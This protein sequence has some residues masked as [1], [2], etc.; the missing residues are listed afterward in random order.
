MIK[1]LIMGLSGAGKTTLA[2]ALRNLIQDNNKTVD[3]FNADLIRQAYDDWDFSVEGRIRQSIRMRDLAD[4]MTSDYVI[5]DFVCPLPVM[6]ENFAAD[7]VVWVDTLTE[8]RYA[9]TNQMFVAPEKYNI[10]VIEQHA[11]KWAKIIY[12]R[13]SHK[14]VE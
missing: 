5:C 2:E 6:R 3:W 8:G 9:D 1:I 7:F 13:I 4:K 12:K 14:G 11:E 10:K